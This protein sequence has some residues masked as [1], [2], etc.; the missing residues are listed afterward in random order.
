MEG[1]V[2]DDLI[3]SFLLKSGYPRASIVFDID[4]LGPT[5]RVGSGMKV[6]AFVIVDPETADPLAVIEVADA[7]GPDALK[8]IAIETGAYASRLAGK[9]IQ[10]FVIRV[11]VNGRSEAEKIQFYRIWPNSTLQRLSSRN[12]PDLEA[13]RVSRQ[14]ILNTTKREVEGSGSVEFKAGGKHSGT[15]SL[16]SD[17]KSDN[18]LRPDAGLYVPALVLLLMI[19]ADF[20]STTFFAQSLLNLSRSVLA[21]GAALLLTLPAA[22]RYFHK[23]SL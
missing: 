11:D 12:F 17:H 5:A 3:Y 13:L 18:K 4:L 10:G 14:L 2:L 15:F 6:P 22:I 21:V 9:A 23:A 19:C 16:Y 8:Q 1:P 7:P 20:L